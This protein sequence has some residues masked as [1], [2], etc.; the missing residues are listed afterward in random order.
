MYY[1]IKN[2]NL[3]G[4]IGDAGVIVALPLFRGDDHMS[5]MDEQHVNNLMTNLSLTPVQALAALGLVD[6]RANLIKTVFL[7]PQ[8][9]SL[10]TPIEGPVYFLA[11]IG[12]YKIWQVDSAQ[13][14][15]LALHAELWAMTPPLTLGMLAVVN[16]FG[17]SFHP[18]AMR[19]ATG[20]TVEQALARRNRIATYLE[21][22]GK[23]AS[24][25]RAAT[26]EHTQMNGICVALGYT[27]TQLWAAMVAG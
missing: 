24:V 17:T 8:I 23:N 19:T 20:M 3:L 27:M 11:D 4:V 14:N 15:L 6:Q 18:S 25:L 13:S 10:Q 1:L 16:V 7:A 26:N 5:L 21:S 12:A 2:N 9:V 22:L